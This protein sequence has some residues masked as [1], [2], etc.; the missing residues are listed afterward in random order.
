VEGVEMHTKKMKCDQ[1]AVTSV[2]VRKMNIAI[3][4]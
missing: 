1:N 3:R 2:A 4:P